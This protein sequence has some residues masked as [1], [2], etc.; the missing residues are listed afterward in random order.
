MPID[1]DDRLDRA[2]QALRDH[3]CQVLLVTPSADLRYLTGYPAHALE[4]LTCLVLPVDGEATL[5]VP[6]LERPA[7]EVATEGIAIVDY[8]D[9]ADAWALIP[10][11]AGRVA[12]ADSMPA[13]HLVPFQ[14]RWPEARWETAG[15]I[16]GPLRAVKSAAEVEALAE[17]GAAIDRVHQRMHLWLEPGRTE[18]AVAADIAAA[19]RQEGH[20]TADFTIVASG[21]NG[22]SPH[23]GSSDRVIQAGDP[24]VVDIGGTMPSGYCSDCTRTYVVGATAPDDF[25]AYY[26]ALQEAQRASVAAVAPGVTAEHLDAVARDQLTAAGFGDAFLHRTGHGI[27]LEGHEDPYIVEG[28]RTPLTEGM[29][30][31]IEP[32]VYLTGRHGARIEDIVACTAAGPRLLN[33]T[34]TDLT[35]L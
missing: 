8:P 35:Y 34:S 10:P 21:P 16:L 3:G 23:H 13:R 32:G 22:A 11:A 1:D 6:R 24:V 4:R 33:T 29:V 15:P 5:V 18:A 9:G 17:A 14:R 28:N 31:S 25:L 2:R 27:G 7:A 20:A 30:F 26:G 19:I 12:V